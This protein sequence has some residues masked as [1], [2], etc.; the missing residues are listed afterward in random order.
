VQYEDTAMFYQCA[1]HFFLSEIYKLLFIHLRYI[2]TQIKV[3]IRGRGSYF[4]RCCG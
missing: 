3:G 4:V 2:K 1:Y